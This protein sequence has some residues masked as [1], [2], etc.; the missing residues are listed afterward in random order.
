MRYAE[1]YER[2]SIGRPSAVQRWFIGALTRKARGLGQTG[3][4]IWT[5]KYLLDNYLDGRTDLRV[6]DAGAWNGWFL[7]YQSP[8][9]A[10][11]VAVDRDAHF[12]PHMARDGI[13]FVQADIDHGHTP[14]ASSTMDLVA[15]LNVLE[16][17][18][19]PL[20]AAAEIARLLRPGGIA[21]VM[22]PD[23]NK[24]R[25]R[26]WDDVT[27]KHPFN[28]ASLRMLFES[29]GLETLEL[30][31]FNHNLFVAGFLFP[32]P[33]HAFFKRFRGRL[34]LYVGRKPGA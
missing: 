19:D 16:H 15:Y 17:L 27:H 4:K 33:L 8:A 12:A 20:A 25:F 2:F 29:H 3:H 10:Q 9:I 14:L 1:N 24:Y 23:V 26:F 5:L 13:H 22:V 28:A 11:K 7:S 18:A 31:A 6:C 34:L 30:G 21:A 32:R